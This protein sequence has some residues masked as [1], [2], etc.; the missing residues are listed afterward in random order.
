MLLCFIEVPSIIIILPCLCLYYLSVLS[1][2]PYW[3]LNNTTI[4]DFCVSMIGRADIEGS[5]SNVAMN[6]STSQPPRVL[7]ELSTVA[8]EQMRRRFRRRRVARAP[9]EGSGARSL[10][11]PQNPAR[12]DTTHIHTYL[13]TYH[14]SSLP[15]YIHSFIHRPSQE[16]APQRVRHSG[17][18]PHHALVTV[19]IYICVCHI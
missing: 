5:D 3:R 2:V 15:T 17:Q 11:L 8:P 9:T 13:P 7:L 18:A 14:P 19:V 1:S 12:P 4:S 6:V 16:A 10:L